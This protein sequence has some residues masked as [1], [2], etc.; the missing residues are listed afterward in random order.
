MVWSTAP[1]VVNYHVIFLRVGS[2]P[3]HAV[4]LSVFGKP[5]GKLLCCTRLRAVEHNDVLA[6]ETIQRQYLNKLIQS[7]VIGKLMP[8]QLGLRLEQS[9]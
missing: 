4:A 8:E 6:L 5:V 7:S 3:F 9:P 2:H 1:E